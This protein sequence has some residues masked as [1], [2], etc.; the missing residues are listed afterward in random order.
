MAAMQ[1]TGAKQ[2]RLRR[3]LHSQRT[4]AARSARQGARM[5][6]G[7]CAA[8][9]RGRTAGR[10]RAHHLSTI[11]SSLAESETAPSPH[12]PPH[13]V[14]VPAYAAQE[15]AGRKRPTPSRCYRRTRS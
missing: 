5:R 14:G 7:P 9:A 15:L 3:R 13:G 2:Y 10:G 6:G 1:R 11:E 4:W 8:A 12:R